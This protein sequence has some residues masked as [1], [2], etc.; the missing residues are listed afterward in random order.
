M[1]VFQKIKT[2][3]FRVGLVP[4]SV[5]ELVHRGHQVAVGAKLEQALASVMNNIVQLVLK[6]RN[7]RLRYSP[8]QI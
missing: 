8:G 1:W 3:E 6:F 4:S 2:R 7:P 5:A